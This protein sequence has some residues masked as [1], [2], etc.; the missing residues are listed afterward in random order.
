M[1]NA[2]RTKQ[3][4]V[5]GGCLAAEGRLW[6][7]PAAQFGGFGHLCRTPLCS[8]PS[9]LGWPQGQLMAGHGH[10][11]GMG[12]SGGPSL[13]RGFLSSEGKQMPGQ[14]VCCGAYHGA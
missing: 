8:P 5:P 13:P 2:L 10:R 3:I 4:I 1:T 9:A 11:V 7:N 12:S 6:K 14:L